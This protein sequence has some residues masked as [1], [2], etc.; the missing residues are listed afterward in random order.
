MATGLP[1]ICPLPRELSFAAVRTQRQRSDRRYALEWSALDP[2]I[3]ECY[4][5]RYHRSIL[6]CL[7]DERLRPQWSPVESRS[8]SDPSQW[9]T[10]ASREY[11]FAMDS[12]RS[13]ADE[14]TRLG[15]RGSSTDADFW[16]ALALNSCDGKCVNIHPRYILYYPRRIALLRAE[17]QAAKAMPTRRIESKA[18]VTDSTL[19]SL[20][21]EDLVVRMILEPGNRGADVVRISN[22]RRFVGRGRTRPDCM[23]GVNNNGGLKPIIRFDLNGIWAGF[24]GWM[25]REEPKM[26]Q[27]LS[28]TRNVRSKTLERERLS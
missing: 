27:P 10:V 21:D 1:R 23:L 15:C 25:G 17:E 11:P 14:V 20:K 7:T 26:S 13:A 5:C 28:P 24:D 19:T 16:H 9:Q 18:R 6:S 12:L 2:T 8:S 3:Y 4:T 22:R